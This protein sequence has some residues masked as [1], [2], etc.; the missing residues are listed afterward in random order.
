VQSLRGHFLVAGPGLVDPNFRRT[1][2]LLGEHGEEGAMGVVLNR[3][4]AA[5]VEEAVPPMA[6][7]TG[8]DEPV[9]LGG[10]VQPQ[11]VVVLAEFDDPGRAEV[12]VVDHVG[13]VPG[14]VEDAAD[15]GALLGVRV[16]AGYAGWG[17]GQLEG[18]LA[19]RAW[20]VLP[21]RGADVFTTEPET[22]WRR[23]LVREGGAYA[24]LSLLPDDPQ[25][26]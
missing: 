8:P 5:T 22:L 25:A 16:F 23:V 9:Y 14:E 18:E 17:P 19:E 11:A 12:I 13:F 21:G 4:S 3:V 20:V 6:P 24:V 7:L 26:N 10:P 15:L 2:V 1:V